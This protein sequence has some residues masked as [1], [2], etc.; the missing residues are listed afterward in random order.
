MSYI[1]PITNRSSSDYT[2]TLIGGKWINVPNNAKGFFNCTAGVVINGITSVDDWGRVYGNAQYVSAEYAAVLPTPPIFT[3]ITAP[4]TAQDPTTMVAK[5]N[6]LL[7]NIELMR[8]GVNTY[9]A[10][11]PAIT[12]L[13]YVAGAGTYAP[14]YTDVNQWESTIDLIK[15]FLDPLSISDIICG[16]ATTGGDY[17]MDAI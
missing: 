2:P 11:V 13:V 8:L 9:G 3:A 5:F 15:T 14:K 1:T 17:V 7:N 10:A 12:T 6:T 4:T 16:V